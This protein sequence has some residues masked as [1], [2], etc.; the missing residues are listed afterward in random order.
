MTEVQDDKTVLKLLAGYGFEQ[1]SDVPASFKIGQSLIG[2]CARE[3]Q[4][5]LVTDVPEGY[6]RVNSSLGK[7][8]PASIV[9]LPVLFEGEAKAVIEFASFRHFNE[10]HLAFLDQLTQ[11]IGIV[12]NTIAATMRTEE[13]LK[14]SQALAEELQKTNR[15]P[16]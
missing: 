3:K 6:L 7:A 16:K 15:K 12:L 10:V 4:R 11:S 8:A 14:Q 9:V 2:Q 1:D 13:L 5:L